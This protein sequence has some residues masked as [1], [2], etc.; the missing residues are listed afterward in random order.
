MTLVMRASSSLLT[1]A[2]SS[3]LGS[4]SPF[5]TAA[6]NSLSCFIITSPLTFHGVPG[7]HSASVRL[8]QL[9]Q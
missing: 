8:Q 6:L 2:S 3:T 4:R 5:D 9:A 7:K 1:L